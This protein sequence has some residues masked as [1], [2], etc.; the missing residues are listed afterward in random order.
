MKRKELRDLCDENDIEYKEK[1][2]KEKLVK[3]IFKFFKK[4]K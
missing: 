4:R 2:E 1:D 3:R